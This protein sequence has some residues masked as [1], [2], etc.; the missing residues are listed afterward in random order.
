MAKAAGTR[1]DGVASLSTG[2]YS[3]NPIYEYAEDDMEA[4]EA[5]MDTTAE[6]PAAPNL[7]TTISVGTITVSASVSAVY[8]LAK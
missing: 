6:S 7:G 2:D 8:F 4:E 5:V 3:Y 1:L